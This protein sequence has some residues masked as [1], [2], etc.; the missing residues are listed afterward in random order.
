MVQIS[1]FD[2]LPGWI[3]S[4]EGEHDLAFAPAPAHLVGTKS[5]TESPETPASNTQADRLG[6]IDR[7]PNYP[8]TRQ[9][10]L[11]R[12]TRRTPKVLQVNRAFSKRSD[13]GWW[14]G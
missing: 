7:I 4:I 2:A 9:N 3:F 1:L 8:L 12:D 14:L 10:S 6:R 11:T 13:E 5:E